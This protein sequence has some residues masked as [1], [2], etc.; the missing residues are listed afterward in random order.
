MH[1]DWRDFLHSLGL[2]AP[3]HLVTDGN[4]HRIPVAG[5]GKKDTDG[6]YGAAEH[7]GKL[8]LDAG[9]WTTTGSET[10]K[11]TDNGT[12]DTEEVQ[13]VWRT[14]AANRQKEQEKKWKAAADKAKRIIG[15]AKP[16]EEHPYLIRKNIKPT[17][18]TYIHGKYLIIPIYQ[19]VD[20]KKTLAGYQRISPHKPKDGTDKLTSAGTRLKGGFHSIMGDS[21]TRYVCEGYATGCTIHEATG[22]TVVVAFMASNLPVVAKNVTGH[23]VVCAD[24]DKPSKQHPEYGGAGH[25]WAKRTG[26]D[27]LSPPDE[28]TDFNDI[29]VEATKEILNPKPNIA[30]IP[31]TE[32]QAEQILF[33]AETVY[34]GAPDIYRRI[35]DEW[36]ASITEP[37][38]GFSFATIEAAMQVLCG[39]NLLTPCHE[40]TVVTYALCGSHS[41]A[42]KDLSSKNPL[43]KLRTQLQQV[44]A[45]TGVVGPLMRVNSLTTGMGNITGDTAFLGHAQETDGSFLWLTTEASEPLRQ[46]STNSS[47]ANQ[48]SSLATALNDSYDGHEIVGKRKAGGVI[49]P[50]DYP[51]IPICWLTQ[52]TELK[53]QLTQKLLE[54]GT[55]GRFDYILDYNPL[56]AQKSSFEGAAVIGEEASIEEIERASNPFSDTTIQ[57][58]LDAIRNVPQGTVLFDRPALDYI[59]EFDIALKEK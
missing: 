43:R 52:L 20:G 31:E 14:L 8:Y 57:M 29:G 56:K 1:K 23:V 47:A 35:Y 37:I 16:V 3:P 55:L 54:I 15:E 34:R 5:K 7:N 6:W 21:T 44:Q 48:G 11:W 32:V 12:T 39:P 19:L 36:M 41:G 9:N 2:E 50:I 13:E 28:G 42:G 33:P 58:I 45:G 26:K 18:G 30:Y 25:Y 53:S 38:A 10:T 4:I 24:T 22:N 51:L 40:R 49:S 27:W 59:S 46:L 17:S